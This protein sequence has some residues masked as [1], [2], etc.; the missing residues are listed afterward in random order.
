[1]KK[2]NRFHQFAK[3]CL[4]ITA[5]LVWGA[6]GV[7]WAYDED[8]LDVSKLR[9]FDG[10]R[11]FDGEIIEGTCEVSMESANR[12]VTLPDVSVHL[13]RKSG[14][15][16]GDTAFSI[17]LVNCLEIN[18][19]KVALRFR[20][21]SFP[22]NILYN[23]LYKGQNSKEPNVGVEIIKPDGTPITLTGGT[24]NEKA[25]GTGVGNV[26]PR[27]D[28]VARYYAFAPAKVGNVQATMNFEILYQ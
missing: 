12:I 13:L 8:Y 23:D 11:I 4:K 2:Q 10:E 14:D 1:M 9:S 25:Q 7:V 21:L 15:T 24:D 22:P 27:F 28:Y 16:A 6:S 17:S 5:L 26:Q 3:N 20:N 18:Y 19:K